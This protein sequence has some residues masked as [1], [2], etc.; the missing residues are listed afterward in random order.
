MRRLFILGL[1]VSVLGVPG[2]ARGAGEEA[3]AGG[4]DE[5]PGDAGFV[6]VGSATPAGAGIVRIFTDTDLNG[7][8]EKMAATFFPYGAAAVGDGVRVAAGD[9]DGDANDEL[10]T[11]SAGNTPVKV[12][13]LESD[14]TPGAEIFSHTDFT[15][16]AYV[17]AGDING[18]GV[19][20]LITSSDAGGPPTVIIRSDVGSTG[21]PD[22]VTDDLNAYAASFTG[23]VP[24]AV[25]DTNNAVGEEL[26]TAPGPGTALAIK[27]FS[28]ADF[29]RAVS[30]HAIL[31]T[32]QPYGNTF[33]GGIYVAAGPLA[34]VAGGGGEVVV[35]PAKGK[36]KVQ[37]R[38]DADGD[39]LISDAGPFEQ[40]FPYG[41]AFAGGVRVGMGDTDGSGS[42]V[43]VITAPGKDA[44]ARPVKLW[45]DDGDVGAFVSD[46]P[47]DDELTGMPTNVT[48]GAFV[49][50]A[51]VLRGTFP[52]E[53]FPEEI[54]DA[55][56]RQSVIRVPR[57]AGIIR[58]LNVFMAISHSFD[59]DL[60]VTLT[61]VPSGTSVILFTDVGGSADG[62]M[63]VL[64]DSAGS[65]IGT[66]THPASGP[67]AGRF[68][69]EDPAVLSVFD[70]LDAS[71]RW[72]LLV[73]D[74]AGG[75]QGT[76]FGWTLNVFF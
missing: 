17:A 35:A 15:V 20:E 25:G 68:D 60:D 75:D 47:R 57:S 61:H 22:T 43:E 13:E 52:Y 30:D 59:G 51:R 31:E 65:D 27:V 9:F 41:A 74:D 23:G 12:F 69:P 64:D 26:I 42:L 70:G 33:T 54:P 45:D 14:G 72:E 71:G 39:G 48:A 50:F 37:I 38:T 40:F 1:A 18:D 7:S 63:I 5:V 76:L 29:D 24:I 11:A 66:A 73:V 4:A 16:G 34:N 46:N 44:G 10:V 56:A 67:I 8:Y 19:D 2:I 58:E 55:G 6:I 36:R 62:F 49:A 21:A 3:E 28:D 32:F 53:G